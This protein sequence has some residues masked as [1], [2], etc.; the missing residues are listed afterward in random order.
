MI[1][2]VV[3]ILNKS[4]NP[5]PEYAH[6]TDSG[7]DIRAFLNKPLVL[8][9]GERYAVPTG[10]YVELPENFEIQVR[11]RSGLALKKG[12]TVINSPGTID[13]NFRGELK[14]I[15]INL[16]KNRQI[17][18]PGER[19]AQLVFATVEKIKFE[20]VDEVS[21]DTD[22]STTGFGDSGRF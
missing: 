10:I 19:I 4:N 17:I 16:D 7:M 8:E 9:P 22:R 11:P 18:E 3:K 20:N 2:K 21:E 12:V 1:D 15:L 13:Q 6:E 14:V 5:N